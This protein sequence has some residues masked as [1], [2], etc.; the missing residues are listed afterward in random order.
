MGEP[1]PFETLVAHHRALYQAGRD[2]AA[3]R[4]PAPKRWAEFGLNVGQLT[5]SARA[6]YW[7]GFSEAARMAVHTRR[8]G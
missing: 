8:T 3:N 6:T 2:D 7:L 4:E 5:P 1:T